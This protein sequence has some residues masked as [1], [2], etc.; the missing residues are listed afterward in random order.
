ME[1][2][3]LGLSRWKSSI[4]QPIRYGSAIRIAGRCGCTTNEAKLMSNRRLAS[5]SDTDPR[6][7]APADRADNLHCDRHTWRTGL[8]QVSLLPLCELASRHRISGKRR[9]RPPSCSSGRSW[10]GGRRPRLTWP[11]SYAASTRSRT[12][13]GRS[14]CGWEEPARGN[15]AGGTGAGHCWHQWVLV[16]PASRPGRAWPGPGGRSR[17]GLFSFQW[18][19]LKLESRHRACAPVPCRLIEREHRTEL[20]MRQSFEN[21]RLMRAVLTLSA[22][23]ALAGCAA[24]ARPAPAPVPP[25]TPAEAPPAQGLPADTGL[26]AGIRTPELLS[27]DLDT[28]EASLFD[29]ARC[30]HSVPAHGLPGARVRLPPDQGGSRKRAWERSGC[31]TA[32]RPSSRPTA[33]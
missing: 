18:R 32:R 28:V 10:T 30:G 11:A 3:E 31:P 7:Y 16:R 2:V 4:Q 9:S 23:L 6:P 29:Q 33:W 12:Y 14:G 19:P 27:A 21:D 1:A 5:Q 20:L 24:A 26:L 22:S 17:H 15:R 25:A 13:R 8:S